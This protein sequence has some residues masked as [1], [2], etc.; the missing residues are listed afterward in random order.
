[1]R[2]SFLLRTSLLMLLCFCCHL[3]GSAQNSVIGV[4]EGWKVNGLTAEDGKV[5]GIADESIVVIAPPKAELKRIKRIK[6]RVV[7]QEAE[8][9]KEVEA[10]PQEVKAEKKVEAIPQEVK[11]EKKVEATPQEVKVEKKV[12]SVPVVEAKQSTQTFTLDKSDIQ[13]GWVI[14]N[15]GKVYAQISDAQNDQAIPIAIIYDLSKNT[16]DNHGLAIALEDVSTKWYTWKDAA[17]AINQWA[18]SYPIAGATWRLP[19]VDDL[20]LLKDDI[21]RKIFYKSDNKNGPAYFYW[22]ATET[23]KYTASYYYFN[24]KKFQSGNKTHAFCVRAIMAF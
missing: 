21:I 17:T 5:S 8:T 10:I 14:A 23:D 3:E 16:N 1:M 6:V 24:T 2:K 4:P 13:V 20:K 7:T 9:E 15:N 18:A 22:T 11:A 12:E 19:S